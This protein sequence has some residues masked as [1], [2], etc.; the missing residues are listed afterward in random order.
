MH[1]CDKFSVPNGLP[2]SDDRVWVGED[3][4]CV[5]ALMTLRDHFAF[6]KKKKERFAD[7]NLLPGSLESPSSRES[8]TSYK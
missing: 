6:P 4:T 7:S 2:E 3:M 8:A 1:I 5:V